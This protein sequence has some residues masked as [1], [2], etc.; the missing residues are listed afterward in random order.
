M[1]YGLAEEDLR[2]IQEIFRHYADVE[3]ALL[4]GSR[5]KGVFK[6]YSDIDIALRGERLTLDTKWHIEE[7]LDNLLLPQKID[8]VLLHRIRNE[9]MLA[10]IRRVGKVLY[11]PSPYTGV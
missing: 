11:P 4:F 10:H 9:E 5:A 2:R 8:L 3:E 7:D 1:Q 6:P